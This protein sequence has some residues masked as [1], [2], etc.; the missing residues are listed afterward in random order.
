MGV[1]LAGE[2]GR[3]LARMRTIGIVLGLFGATW[4]YFYGPVMTPALHAAAAAR[5]N[6]M[7]ESN[8]RSYRLHWEVGLRPHWLCGN[9]AEPE[10]RPVDLG[11]VVVPGF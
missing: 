1:K 11:W 2:T 9:A 3:S 7:A 5:C 6:E 4:F 8:Y 10:A